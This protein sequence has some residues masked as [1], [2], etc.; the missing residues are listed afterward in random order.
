MKF[1]ARLVAKCFPPKYGEDY[2]ETFAPV[3]S[4]ATIRNFLVMTLYKV[5]NL[6]HV[7]IKNAFLQGELQKN[8]YVHQPESYVVL[9]QEQKMCRFKKAM[10]GLKRL[11]GCGT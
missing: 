3:V 11:L 5:L 10:Y 2:E 7:D 1:K 8:I 6:R 9:E 4:H